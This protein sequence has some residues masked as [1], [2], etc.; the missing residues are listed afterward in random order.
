MLEEE[1]EVAQADPP[2]EIVQVKGQV[3]FEHVSFG[4]GDDL[5][6]K[7]VNIN[8]KPGQMVALVGP[9]GAGRQR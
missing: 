1:E 2:A 7:D 8:V 5:L 9:T 3:S 4:Y 6:M